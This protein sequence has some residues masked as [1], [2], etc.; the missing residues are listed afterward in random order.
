MAQTFF[1]Q[2]TEGG[3]PLIG[4]CGFTI[5]N[6][7]QQAGVAAYLL[8]VIYTRLCSACNNA[9]AKVVEI[10]IRMVVTKGCART[11]S[12]AVLS[13]KPIGSTITLPDRI[14]AGTRTG[15]RNGD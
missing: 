2:R 5:D 11:V 10:A 12:P 7:D 15:D 3:A 13:G 6:I 9:R 1:K 4:H 14:A 8:F